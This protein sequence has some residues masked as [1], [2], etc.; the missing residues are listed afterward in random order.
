M[1][2]DRYEH[3]GVAFVVDERDEGEPPGSPHYYE[4]FE[5]FVD[6]E[7]WGIGYRSGPDWRAELVVDGMLDLVDEDGEEMFVNGPRAEA[8]SMELLAARVRAVHGRL[9][10]YARDLAANGYREGMWA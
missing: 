9:P 5:V 3:E 4:R 10:E 8:P 6:G 1:E 2:I 7:G